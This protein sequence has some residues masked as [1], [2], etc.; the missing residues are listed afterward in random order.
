MTISMVRGKKAN[1]FMNVARM[2]NVIRIQDFVY[3]SPVTAAKIVPYFMMKTEKNNKSLKL[4]GNG[5]LNS[6]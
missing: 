1:V 5:C 2:E 6:M 4:T 3:A